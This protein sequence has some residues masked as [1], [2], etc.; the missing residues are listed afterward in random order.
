M[1][2]CPP[3]ITRWAT[4]AALIV[5]LEVPPKRKR[6]KYPDTAARL[7][8]GLRVRREGVDRGL[9]GRPGRR[10]AWASARTSRSRT[11]TAAAGYPACGGRP[12]VGRAWSTD[13]VSP[14]PPYMPSPSVSLSHTSEDKAV[15]ETP[16]RRLVTD[17]DKAWF[18]GSEIKVGDEVDRKI[19]PVPAAGRRVR[20]RPRAGLP[21][22]AAPHERVLHAGRA[23]DARFRLAEAVARGEGGRRVR[24]L[25][26]FSR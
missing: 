24:A 16:A 12:R 1:T 8:A 26:S 10:R 7:P 20:R 2:V 23:R 15:V 5:G 21:P 14:Y 18:A 25:T 22:R 13:G 6:R 3:S 17:G 9:A 11:S 4:R 19:D